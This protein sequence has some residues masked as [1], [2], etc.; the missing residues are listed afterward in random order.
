MKVLANIIILD[1]SGSMQ[2]EKIRTSVS[3][4][5]ELISDKSLE[6]DNVRYINQL[7][8]VSTHPKMLQNSVTRLDKVEG[9]EPN[10]MTALYDT[11]GKAIDNLP[12]NLDGG[13]INIFT[14]GVEN[15]SI[16]Y[17]L[18]EIKTKL[19]N[20]RKEN[21]LITYIGV[22]EGSLSQGVNLGV[23]RGNTRFS[24]SVG[25]FS[26]QYS[27]VGN[28]RSMYS[29]NMSGGASFN[30]DEMLKDK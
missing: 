15:R 22:D 10:G 28:T 3:G 21:W 13:M 17:T 19:E 23:S 14:D 18:A 25:E 1:T 27:N 9:I 12:S 11:I 24:K 6:H 29:M 26:K 20:L 30:A 16:N 8:S 2:G 7:W 4:I 5:N